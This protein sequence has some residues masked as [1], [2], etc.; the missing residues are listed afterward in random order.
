MTN[1]IKMHLWRYVYLHK[2]YTYYTPI[3]IKVLC[4]C[5]NNCICLSFL[6]QHTT[7]YG[8]LI[9][10]P[11]CSTSSSHTI[12]NNDND[13]FTDKGIIILGLAFIA[14]AF[15]NKNRT[16]NRTTDR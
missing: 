14:L 4:H 6:N 1:P 5:L 2:V 11:F 10:L 8:R 9:M 15:H 12:L 3:I 16:F 13:Y 7:K